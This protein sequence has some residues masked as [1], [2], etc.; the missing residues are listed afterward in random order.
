MG[1]PS[2]SRA[3]K[4]ACAYLETVAGALERRGTLEDENIA[5]AR[6]GLL[7]FAQGILGAEAHAA[8]LVREVVAEVGAR[9]AIE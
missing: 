3:F 1:S 2:I 6:V 8:W 7:A 9:D 4:T 5:V